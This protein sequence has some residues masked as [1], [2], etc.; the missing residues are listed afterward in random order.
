MAIEY[1][2][3]HYSLIVCFLAVIEYYFHFFNGWKIF[4]YL[5]SVQFSNI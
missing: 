3:R 2:I 4:R 5:F 1:E